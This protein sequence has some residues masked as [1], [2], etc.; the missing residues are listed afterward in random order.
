MLGES[1]KMFYIFSKFS[2]AF[3]EHM[4]LQNISFYLTFNQN[5]FSK[6]LL[7][8]GDLSGFC[9]FNFCLVIKRNFFVGKLC[10]QYLLPSRGERNLPTI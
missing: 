2:F 10:H 5:I 3:P 6:L 8:L 9:G 4:Q 7:E 1:Q